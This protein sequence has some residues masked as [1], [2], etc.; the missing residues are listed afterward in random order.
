MNALEYLC[1]Y[2]PRNPNNL[3]DFNG[4]SL[5]EIKEKQRDCYC[6]NCHYGRT[7]LAERIIELEV[8]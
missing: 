2:D 6:D 1:E 3:N 8:K 4:F 5:S 7:E